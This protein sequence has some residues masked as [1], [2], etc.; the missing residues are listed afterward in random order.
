MGV[1]PP[2]GNFPKVTEIPFCNLEAVFLI[3]PSEASARLPA[4]GLSPVLF[5][6]K[7][8]ANCHSSFTPR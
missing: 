5:H 3:I 7:P 2:I 1:E 6:E 8:N 4:I